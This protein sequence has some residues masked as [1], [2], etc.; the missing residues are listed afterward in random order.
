MSR[1]SIVFRIFLSRKVENQA[2]LLTAVYLC[3]CLCVCARALA[4]VPFQLLNNF[5]DVQ[6]TWHEYY[7]TGPTQQCFVISCN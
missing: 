7:A 3:V 5:T 4:F 6:Q 2:L 1:M